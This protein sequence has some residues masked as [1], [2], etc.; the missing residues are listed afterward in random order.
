MRAVLNSR[1]LVQSIECPDLDRHMAGRRRTAGVERC[2][3]HTY[4]LVH[5]KDRTECGS[6]RGGISLVA[7]AG[8]VLLEAIA[9]RLMRFLRTGGYILHTGGAVRL[10]TSTVDD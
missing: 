7:H 9:N 3:D 8:K 1:C 5:K 10:Q 4:Y 2:H 6:Y